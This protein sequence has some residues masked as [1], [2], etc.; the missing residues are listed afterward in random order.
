[1]PPLKAGR[2]T[3]VVFF[4]YY[5]GK[6]NEFLFSAG[7]NFGLTD[8]SLDFFSNGWDNLGQVDLLG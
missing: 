7:L 6:Q 1:M 5:S 4:G 2:T 8:Y 3:F